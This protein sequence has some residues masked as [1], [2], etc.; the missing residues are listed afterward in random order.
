MAESKRMAMKN[1]VT[2]ADQAILEEKYEFIP[3]KKKQTSWQDRMV[4]RYQSGLY[5]EYA[6]ADLSRPGKVGL[7]W[8]TKKEVL[9]GIGERTC[10]NKA[11]MNTDLL[12]TLRVPFAYIEQGVSKMDMV[13]LRLC[14]KCE[15]FV[16]KKKSRR[17]P[18]SISKK[19]ESEK[20]EDK[21]I[22]MKDTHSD[23]SNKEQESSTKSE[24]D[25]SSE[26]FPSKDKGERKRYDDEDDED[27]RRSRKR[28]KR[29]HRSSDSS[30][31]SH[32]RR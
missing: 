10:G 24:E 8:R 29:S 28:K 32:D 30:R 12:I 1:V 6:L 20:D 5:K 17:V 18:Q 14:P 7:R 26:R 25:S 21:Q 23:D 3:G 9:E 4:E 15:P 11:C 2:D 16:T 19:T 31:K 27:K 13:K 22:T